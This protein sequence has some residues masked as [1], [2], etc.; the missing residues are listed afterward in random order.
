MQADQL[1]DRLLERQ[2]SRCWPDDSVDVCVCTWNVRLR[3]GGSTRGEGNRGQRE[4]ML[5]GNNGKSEMLEKLKSK[6]DFSGTAQTL[7]ELQ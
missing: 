3:E 4:A 1:R 2:K 7:C 6:H 5:E